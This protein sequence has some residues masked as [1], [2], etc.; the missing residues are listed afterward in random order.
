GAAILQ[1]RLTWLELDL[2]ERP[3]PYGPRF[4]TDGFAMQDQWCEILHQRHG[5]GTGVVDRD[6]GGVAAI[7]H[8]LALVAPL[9]ALQAA[10]HLHG[11]VP[12]AGRHRD[13]DRLARY[14]DAVGND[15]EAASEYLVFV[16]TP[17][18]ARPGD[19]ER[20]RVIHVP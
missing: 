7:D 8:G 3:C 19:V 2:R 17:P 11:V 18:D 15:V 13:R 12:A 4:A 20:Q 6:G 10:D 9:A 1:G 5:A 14:D 16:R